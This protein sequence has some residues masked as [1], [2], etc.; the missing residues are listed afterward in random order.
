MKFTFLVFP[1]SK[2]VSRAQSLKLGYGLCDELLIFPE[3]LHYEGATLRLF[4]QSRE[5]VDVGEL[6]ST[7]VPND[8]FEE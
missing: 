1:V 5:V 8:C 6:L 7:N 3:T 4:E 2:T